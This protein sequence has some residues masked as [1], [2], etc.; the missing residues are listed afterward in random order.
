MR[1]GLLGL[2]NVLKGNY[3][4]ILLALGLSLAVPVVTF[5]PG[6]WQE[7]RFI[8]E[9]KE[10]SIRI[11]SD[12]ESV[13]DLKK[14]VK[15]S[16]IFITFE[17][18]S[19]IAMR[20]SESNIGRG[21]ASSV[22]L[23]ITGQWYESTVQRTYL[24]SE[25]EEKAEEYRELCSRAQAKC[26]PN[27]TPDELLQFFFEPLHAVVKSKTLDEARYHLANMGFMEMEVRR[28]GTGLE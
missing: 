18:N 6:L 2:W 14:A 3:K 12:A 16:G 27:T 13:A 15:P 8:A 21:P 19:W 9:M 10:N 23:D 26:D 24:F 4:E 28:R 20:Y 22:A 11:L 7:R 17:D 25:Y 1:A 5:G